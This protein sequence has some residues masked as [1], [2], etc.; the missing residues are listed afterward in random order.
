M[1]KHNWLAFLIILLISIVWLRL[2]NLLAHKGLITSR[3]SRKVIH[4]GT[5]P[6][7]VVCWLLFND[8]P[9]SRYLAAIIPL[10]ITLQFAL[11]GLRVI[12]DP[13]S[14]E[15]MSRSGDPR[16]I[17]RGPLFYGIVFVIITIFF[18]KN[19][20]GIIALMMMCGGDGLADLIG[21]QY[22]KMK[23]PWSKKKTII[24]SLAVLVGGF[25]LSLIVLWIYSLAGALSGPL[26]SHFKPLLIISLVACLVESLPVSDIDNVTVPTA[27]IIAGYLLYL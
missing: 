16:E 3:L 17:L 11:I 18:W 9:S 14:V 7:F 4:I 26:N 8:A 2:V 12:K 24:G 19:H 20:I 25:F 15:A 13:S 22:G 5:G 21:K 27:S 1:I 6:I 23:L 10:A